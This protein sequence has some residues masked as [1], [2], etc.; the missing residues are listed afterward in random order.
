MPPDEIDDAVEV[1][2]ELPRE[3]RLADACDPGDRHEVRAA[4]RRGDVEQLLD[5]L[6]LA[7]AADEG[8]LE[9]GRLQRAADTRDDAQRPPQ[10]DGLGLALE[11]ALARA[12]EHERLLARAPR[13]LAD[14]HRAGL[15]CGLHPRCRVDEVAGDHALTLGP[16]SHRGFAG[17]NTG[18]RAQARGELG[19]G[20]DE[21][22]RRANRTLGVALGRGRRP[23]HRHHRVAD[24]LLDSAAVAADQ[25]SRELEVARQELTGLLC[26]ASLRRG[27]EAD[28]VGEQHR[29]ETALGGRGGRD[30]RRGTHLEG[31]AAG[32]A[33]PLPLGI[34]APARAAD[35]GERAAAAAAEPLPCGILGSAVRAGVH[36]LDPS[37]LRR[38]ETRR[39]PA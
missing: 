25:R 5:Q 38:A 10:R 26:V 29:H 32:T 6:E 36:P 33:E 39:R 21:V 27:R 15:G 12:L 28:Q 11:L 2:V 37:R 16:E 14:E 30:R 8:R 31:S 3:P 24:E 23:P 13:R 34:L 22:E 35:R 20:R 17:E 18:P 19:H 9:P 4:V 7:L 1:L